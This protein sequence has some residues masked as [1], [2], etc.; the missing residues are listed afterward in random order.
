MKNIVY[1]LILFLCSCQSNTS[2]EKKSI[3]TIPPQTIEKQQV[4]KVVV[5]ND[6]DYSRNFYLELQKGEN[7][8]QA[9]LRGNLLI[10][11]KIDTIQFPDYPK[12][13]EYTVLTGRKDNLAIA[14]KVKRVNQSSIEYEVEMVEFGKTNYSKN[15][16]ADLSPYFYL[17]SESDED[18]ITGM[19]FLSS[20]FSDNQDSCQTHIRIG[21]LSNGQ[22]GPLVAKL[23][24]NCNGKIK[25][26]D[27]ENFPLLREK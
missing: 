15:G 20:E 18:E 4:E 25:D 19:S 6:E 10:L 14:L 2:S 11:N 13:N 5:E 24:K 21:I 23:I 17:G 1:L 8:E 7:F 27:L 3:K 22:N 12:L 9:E 16:I 26:I